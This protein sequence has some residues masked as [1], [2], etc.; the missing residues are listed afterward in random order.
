MIRS[1]LMFLVSLS[2]ISSAVLELDD[3][4]FHSLLKLPA[5]GSGM[6]LEFYAPWCGACKSVAPE[7]EAASAAGAANARWVKIDATSHRALALRF[8][9]VSY[10]TFFHL[11]GPGGSHVRTVSVRAWEAG[12]FVDFASDGWRRIK[13]SNEEIP[14]KINEEI[15]L[16]R[17]FS[18]SP[19]S[20]SASIQYKFFRLAERALAVL[21]DAAIFVG[22][23]PIAAQIS[24]ATGLLMLITA[25]IALCAVRLGP[26]KASARDLNDLK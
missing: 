19:F 20:V 22:L 17:S 12:A 23:P 11:S 16:K 7:W 21:E 15:P 6:M 2:V 24:A 3:S 26:R 5:V 8:G 25:C 18:S 14:L 4:T 10:P 13:S 9:V 1:L